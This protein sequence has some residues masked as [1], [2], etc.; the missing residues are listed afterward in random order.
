MREIKFRYVFKHK[1]KKNIFTVI[2]DIEEIEMGNHWS[3]D[4]SIEEYELIAR[5]QYTGRKDKNGK[6]IYEGNI[7]G[8]TPLISDFKGERFRFV[9]EFKEG[10]FYLKCITGNGDRPIKDAINYD[11]EGN[12]HENSELLKNKND[13]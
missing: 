6:E 3:T 7:Y 2:E 5:Q 11:Y 13:K 4:M 9:V 1:V 10:K 12:V 8:F